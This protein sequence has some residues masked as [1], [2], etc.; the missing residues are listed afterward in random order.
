ME[1]LPNR[2]AIAREIL[3]CGLILATFVQRP[4]TA[5][6][7]IHPTDLPVEFYSH[8]LDV[9]LELAI[10]RPLGV[11]NVVPELRAF[12]THFT[13]CHRIFTSLDRLRSI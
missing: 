8:S 9:G 12:A 3:E 1:W 13:L 4:Q 5:G 2:G 10:G 7:Q 6:A 11:A